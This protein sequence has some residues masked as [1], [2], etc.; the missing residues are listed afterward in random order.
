MQKIIIDDIGIYS[1]DENCLKN[2][3]KNKE[4]TKDNEINNNKEKENKTS[5]KTV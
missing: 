2:K 1:L 5:K 3:Q 4:C